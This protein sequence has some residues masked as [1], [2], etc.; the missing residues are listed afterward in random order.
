MRKL[1]CVLALCLASSAAHAMEFLSVKK[2]SAVMFDAPDLSSKK[3]FVV[4]FGYPVESLTDAGNWL[5]VRDAAGSITWMQ[6]A[7]LDKKRTLLVTAPRVDVRQS[8]A[9]D[10]PVVFSVTRDVWLEWQSAPNAAWVKVRHPQDGAQGFAP[11]Q[12]F[13]GL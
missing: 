12:A 2:A 5:R 4:G 3:L 8:A 6:R 13:W 1:A 7:D 9:D 11:I 10:A